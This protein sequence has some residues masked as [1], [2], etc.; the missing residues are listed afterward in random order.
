ME[1]QKSGKNKMQSNSAKIYPDDNTDLTQQ[2]R[3]AGIDGH[4]RRHAKTPRLRHS[5]AALQVKY[6]AVPFLTQVMFGHLQ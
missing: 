6:P 4:G 5:Y 2:S 3:K 1:R